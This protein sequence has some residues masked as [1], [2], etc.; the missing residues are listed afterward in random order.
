MLRGVLGERLRRDRFFQL[1]VV[2]TGIVVL[3]A[4]FAPWIA[5]YDP[6]AGDLPNAHLLGPGGRFL[7]GTD[8]QGRAAQALGALDRRVLLRHLLPNVRTRV[9]ISATPGIA[10]G[11]AV[12]GFN[13]G[14][15]A[16]RVAHDPRLRN[17]R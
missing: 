4:L 8:S 12:L 5:P 13:L 17:E 11:L 6:I 15:D 9:I 14:G 16:L 7:L 3:A 1:G 2:L 10:I